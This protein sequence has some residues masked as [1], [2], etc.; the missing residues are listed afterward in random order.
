M[1]SINV[2]GN[3]QFYKGFRAYTFPFTTHNFSADLYY[4]DWVTIEKDKNFV[5]WYAW[6]ATLLYACLWS[7][8]SCCSLDRT[9][10]PYFPLAGRICKFYASIFDPWIWSILRCLGLVRHQQQANQLS[11]L[12]I[13]SHIVGKIPTWLEKKT[14]RGIHEG[15]INQVILIKFPYMSWSLIL[16]NYNSI[17]SFSVT[18]HTW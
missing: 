7:K 16:S 12:G 9:A 18:C 8:W 13:N 3:G 17:L 2:C 10:D 14:G 1:S 5:G 6:V 4:G 11:S 15:I